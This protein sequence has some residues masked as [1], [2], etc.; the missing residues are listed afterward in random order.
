MNNTFSW[1]RFCQVVTK[2]FRNL[3]PLFGTT[4]LILAVLPFAAWLLV[5][6]IGNGH[7]V[8]PDIRLIMIETVAYIAAIMA[9]S[10]M[11]RTWN[12]HNEGIYFAMLPASKLEK[13]T[14]ALL[15]SLIICPLAVMVGSMAVDMVLTALPFGPYRQWLWQGECGFPFTNLLS[16]S[17]EYSLNDEGARMFQLFNGIL[18]MLTC[19]MGYIASVS[20]FLFTSTLFKKH[21]VL[22]TILWLYVIN[23]AMSLVLTPLFVAAM[24]NGVG[25]DFL[26]WVT[27]HF[28][29]TTEEEI[30]R[31]AL[32]IGIAIN[33][34]LIALFGWLSWRRLNRMSY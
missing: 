4:M 1:Q 21:K 23:F 17:G 13:F 24:A 12:L 28:A 16:W 27:T 34:L 31:G 25:G 19:W 2:D 5:A 20:M 26:Q 14:S 33:T 15:Y 32:W 30:L 11:Y 3:W 10:R 9:P 18:Y 22:Q 29:N 7:S 6:V 8:P